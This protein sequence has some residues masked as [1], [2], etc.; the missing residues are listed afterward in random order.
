MAYPIPIIRGEKAGVR[1]SL[2][3]SYAK[4]IRA[5]RDDRWKL[6]VYPQIDHRQLFDLKNDPH[7][8]KNLAGTAEV[9]DQ[10]KRLETLLKKWQKD[11]DDTMPLRVENP[12]PKE[13]DLTGHKRKPD[14]HQPKWIVEKYF[15][16]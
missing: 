15:D 4:F 5:V 9:A 3:T 10:E 2:F 13:M 14:R 7:E 1:E 11:V 16:K 6:I 8:M 12:K